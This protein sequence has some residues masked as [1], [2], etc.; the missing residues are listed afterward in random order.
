MIEYPDGSRVQQLLF[1]FLMDGQVDGIRPQETEVT[2]YR[3][4]RPDE[5]PEDTM[6][7]CKQKTADLIHYKGQTIFR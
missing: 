2:A 5:I 1:F 4:V 3:F 6:E 7:C